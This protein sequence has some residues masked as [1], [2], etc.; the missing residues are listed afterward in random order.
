MIVETDRLRDL[1]VEFFELAPETAPGD[2]VQER[3]AEWDSLAMV[4]LIV[5]IQNVFGVG[6][7]VEE[8]EQLASYSQIRQA[9]NRKGVKVSQ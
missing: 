8:I 7:D 2:I 6:F 5:E 1:L 9:L 4:Q 3:I